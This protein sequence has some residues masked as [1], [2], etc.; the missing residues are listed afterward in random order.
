[1][2]CF[3]KLFKPCN[4]KTSLPEAKIVGDKILSK[5][6]DKN[7]FKLKFLEDNDYKIY[8]WVYILGQNKPSIEICELKNTSI[9]TINLEAIKNENKNIF[10]TQDRKII[11]FDEGIVIFKENNIEK[12]IKI[13]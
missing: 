6:I 7:K 10:V 8:S 9:S 5:L 12:I 4:L 11:I 3:S 2:D 13:R 1:M